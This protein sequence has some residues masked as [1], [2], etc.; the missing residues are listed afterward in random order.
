MRKTIK[1][2]EGRDGVRF[3]V[4]EKEDQQAQ[5]A[6]AQKEDAIQK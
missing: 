3:K 5:A 4:E 6:K 1:S 2:E